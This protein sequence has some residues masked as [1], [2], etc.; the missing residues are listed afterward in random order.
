MSPTVV[1]RGVPI[2]VSAPSGGGKTTL[3]HRVIEQLQ[4]IE[5]SVSHTTRAPR[6]HEVDG[7]DYHFVDVQTFTTLKEANAFV[8]H[9]K[10]FNN[11][12]GTSAAE[13]TAR[14]DAG[15]DVLFDIDV[16]GG[17]QIQQK[18]PEAVLVF[19]VPPN[20]RE[21]ERR[22]RSRQTDAADEIAR[23]LQGAEAEIRAAT[24]YTHWVVNDSLDTAADTLQSIVCSERLRHV[25]KA[26]LMRQV[27]QG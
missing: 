18:M 14:L 21:L 12:Y 5:F 17:H 23:R 1:R 7:T 22:L 26:E 10:V 2:V 19:I 4:D 13:A 3:C 20:M 6:P 8:E 11:W 25:D 16:Q 27:L 15:I 24:F 9:A